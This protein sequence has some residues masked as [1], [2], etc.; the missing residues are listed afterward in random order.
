MS[1]RVMAWV[2]HRSKAKGATRLVALAIAD[3]ASD[4]GTNAWPSVARLASMCLCSESTVRRA[5]AELV[6]LSELRVEIQ[7][8]GPK[9]MRD[10]KRP[11]RYTFQIRQ[12]VDNPV[13]N[14]IIG[15]SPMT[16]RGGNGVSKT[17]LRGVT[18]DTLSVLNHPINSLDSVT[19]R[20]EA[21][22]VDNIDNS[23]VP[24]TAEEK[25]QGKKM[26]QDLREAR[27]R[28][29]SEPAQESYIP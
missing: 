17:V 18:D 2:G 29:V 8:G 6:E 12:H 22:A 28:A 21:Q 11:N 3:H 16:G 10:D 7:A 15:V 26:L 25:E 24:L 5:I 14:P 9:D 19:R 4:D 20:G 27:L 23:F 1:V 13:D